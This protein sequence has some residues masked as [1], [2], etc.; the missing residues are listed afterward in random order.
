M[1]AFVEETRVMLAKRPNAPDGVIREQMQKARAVVARLGADSSIWA[2]DDLLA[3]AFPQEWQAFG[4]T[5]RTTA[6]RRI[7]REASMECKRQLE[8]A[9]KEPDGQVR[10][11]KTAAA[12]FTKMDR[13]GELSDLFG[14]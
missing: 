7:R 11:A 2:F 9:R 12:I 1:A 3:E 4:E 14:H 8:E 13:L 10:L 5:Q 6:I